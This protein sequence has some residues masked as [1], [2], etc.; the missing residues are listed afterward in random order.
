[1]KDTP[2][3]TAHKEK[4]STPR[5]MRSPMKESS[6]SIG[7]STPTDQKKSISEEE[8]KEKLA[9]KR[10]QAREKAEREA[11]EERLKNEEQV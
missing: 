7:A 11:E 1:M 5:E 3:K 9:E 8:Y 4:V 2:K 6:T 10:R